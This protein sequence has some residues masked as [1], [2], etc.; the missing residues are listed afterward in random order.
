MKRTVLLSIIL[1]T[2]P[3]NAGLIAIGKHADIRWRWDASAG[4]T[5]LVI[6]DGGVEVAH[7]PQDVYFPLSDKPYAGFDAANS[8]ARS[9][10]STNAAFA[11]IGVQP[12]QPF[13][14]AVQGT[15][16]NGEAWPGIENNQEAGTFGSYIPADSRVSQTNARPWIKVSLVGY[17]P[18]PGND[19]HFSLWNTTTGKPPT[20]WMSTHDTDVIN[21]YYYSEGSHTHMNW[22]FSSLGV[23]RVSLKASAF[24]G[25]GANNPTGESAT[26][27]FTFAIGAF[28]QWQASHFS[29]SELDDPL[30]CGPQADPDRDGMNNRIEFGFGFHPRQASMVPIATGLGLPR[31]SLEPDGEVLRY[32]RRR[33]GAQWSPLAYHP[34]FSRD[35]ST[36]HANGV[37]TTTADF[38]AEQAALNAV[39]E[40]VEARRPADVGNDGRG[41][42]RV[43]VE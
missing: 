2:A 40:M 36:W 17:T 42:A 15:P 6:D 37:T 13:W 11:F 30:V 24:A 19:G 29:A 31:M 34:R 39:W 12:G 4:W 16:G 9:I 28:A 25:P 7:D 3:L 27:T 18:P 5:C 23:H 41:F 32:P 20:V 10:Q 26:Y 33:A 14:R 1:A 35:L 8:G 22:G 21:D 43:A 38:P